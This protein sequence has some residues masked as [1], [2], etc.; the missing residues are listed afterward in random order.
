MERFGLARQG[1]DSQCLHSFLRGLVEQAFVEQILTQQGA[2][3]M[4]PM[5][6]GVAAWTKSELGARPNV[7]AVYE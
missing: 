7:K 1:R 3:R 6:E 4:I 5:I 2:M